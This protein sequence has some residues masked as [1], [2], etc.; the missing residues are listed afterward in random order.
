[1]G[2][3]GLRLC[4]NIADYDMVSNKTYIPD[5]NQNK[6]LKFGDALLLSCKIVTKYT[7]PATAFTQKYR[8]ANLRMGPLY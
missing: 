7:V 3:E 2:V 1:M 5:L 8:F 4:L 6:Y